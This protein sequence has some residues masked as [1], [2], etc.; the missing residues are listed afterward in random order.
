MH[1]HLTEITVRSLKPAGKQR[2]VWDT[3]TPG[4]GVIVGARSKSYFVMY[5]TDRR[6]KILGR[7]PDVPLGEARR[8][9]LLALN[10]E[11]PREVGAEVSF[12][13]AL[14][15]FFEVHV[16]TLRPRTQKELKRVLNRHLAPKLRSKKLAEITHGDITSI[17]DKL[18]STPSEAWH[19]F[20]DIRTFFKWCVPRYIPH[21]PVEGL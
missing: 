16:P 15:Q 4:F 1:A 17:T 21:S 18:A 20:K 2:K 6:V 19:A 11:R 14:E 12:S 10:S 8:K 7:Y 9:A 13:N 5:G 3:T